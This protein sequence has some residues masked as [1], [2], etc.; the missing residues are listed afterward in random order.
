[1]QV[2]IEGKGIENVLRRLIG[3]YGVLEDVIKGSVSIED[4]LKPL[5]QPDMD[6][7]RQEVMEIARKV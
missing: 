1:M 4:V 6:S 5:T 2:G 7:V 3:P